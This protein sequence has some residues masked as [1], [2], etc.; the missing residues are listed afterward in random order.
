M[1]YLAKMLYAGESVTFIARRIMICASEDVGNADPQA[2]QVATACAQAVE[3]VGM[4]EAQIILAQA[5]TYVACAP[6]SNAVVNAI[7]DAMQAVKEVG[8][9]Q[10]PVYLRDA[11]YSGAEKLG[12]VGY[13]YAHDYENHY[14]EQQYL[15]DQL[16]GRTFYKPGNLGYEKHI[17]DWFHLIKKEK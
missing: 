7:F 3:R 4:P 13:K 8:N 11:H 12:N 5:A 9:C 14:V 10:V 2:I 17:Q 6:K 16:V 1:Y 15:P